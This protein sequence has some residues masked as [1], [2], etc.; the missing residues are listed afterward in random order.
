MID[1]GKSWND[2]PLTLTPRRN[3]I[4]WNDL[5]LTLTPR[6]IARVLGLGRNKGYQIFQLPDFPAIRIGRCLRVT[7][8]AFIRWLETQQR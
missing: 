3:G 2:L 1:P 5:P 4:S 6:D 8:E 7:R